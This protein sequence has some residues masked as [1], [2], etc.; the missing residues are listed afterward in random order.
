MILYQTV[1]MKR[2]KKNSS[3]SC[4]HML[5]YHTNI[6]THVWEMTYFLAFQDIPNVFPETGFVYLIMIQMVML[7]IAGMG[8]I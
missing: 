1:Q 5:L 7:D 8:C 2:M 6:T 4:R 3:S